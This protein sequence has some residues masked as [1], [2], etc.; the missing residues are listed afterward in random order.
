MR[1][2]ETEMSATNCKY[3]LSHREKDR[4]QIHSDYDRG[5]DAHF[6][7][8]WLLQDDSLIVMVEPLCTIPLCNATEI[9]S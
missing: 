5:R 4:P 1:E 6:L 3:S 8:E 9:L 7:V 2:Q